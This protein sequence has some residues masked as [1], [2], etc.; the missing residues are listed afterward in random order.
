MTEPLSH[1][2]RRQIARQG[3][4]DAIAAWGRFTGNI[5]TAWQL[6]VAGVDQDGDNTIGYMTPDGQ[7]WVTTLGLVTATSD[8]Y[9]VRRRA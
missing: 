4:D 9:R 5:I 1:D 8:N 3:L 2:E 6:T 7:A